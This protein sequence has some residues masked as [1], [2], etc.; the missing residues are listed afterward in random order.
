[1]AAI[2]IY[3][4]LTTIVIVLSLDFINAKD[5]SSSAL[6][7]RHRIT[8]KSIGDLGNFNRCDKG[9][10]G[11]ERDGSQVGPLHGKQEHISV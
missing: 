9:L 1:M 6:I 11:G 7:R 2:R 4:L 5:F 3:M 10:K 8:A